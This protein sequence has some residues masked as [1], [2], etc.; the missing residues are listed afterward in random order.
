M[1]QNISIDSPYLTL[2][3]K[4][5]YHK[6]MLIDMHIH[7]RFSPCSIIRVAQLVRKARETGLDGICITDHDTTASKSVLKNISDRQS[8]C[9]IVGMEYTT[10]KG[11]FLVFGPV[12]DITS[13]MDAEEL[14]K[15]SKK[16][17]AILIPAHPFREE[18]P[19]DMNILKKAK[20]IEGLNGRN[21]PHENE[22]CQKW[23]REHGNGVKITGGSDA[24]TLE[25]VGRIVTVFKNNI[26]NM[27]DLIE[28]LRNNNYSPKQRYSV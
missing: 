2:I 7:T 10:R 13:G 3:K 11:D 27:E 1:G 12:E 16:E 5:S 9:I 20:I 19:A 21:R 23:L 4:Y 26:Y 24:H 6:I 22:L 8:L 18:R 17:G 14:M 15:W 28:D 25:E